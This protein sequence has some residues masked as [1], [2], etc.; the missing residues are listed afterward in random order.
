ML[1]AAG[2]INRSYEVL[3]LAQAFTSR[4]EKAGCSGGGLPISEAYDDATK[5]LVKSAE[6][7]GADGLIHINYSYRVSVVQACGQAG[8]QSFEVYAWGTAIRLG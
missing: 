5:R 7:M 8:K 4:V 1:I 3:G 6:D 2:N